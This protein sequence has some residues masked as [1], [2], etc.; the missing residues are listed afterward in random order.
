MRQTKFRGR[1]KYG[2]KLWLI[3][4]KL[5]VNGETFIYPIDETVDSPDRYEVDPET[6]G[7]FTTLFD[8]AKTEIFEFDFLQYEKHPG[9]L[10]PSGLLFVV[11]SVEWA[12]F[13]YIDQKHKYFTP[14]ANHDEIWHD[15]L[16]HCTVVGNKDN[17]SA[18]I[19]PD[20]S[21]E[22]GLH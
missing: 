2:E 12:C 8:C 10:M 13:G 17:Y 22:N 16:Q 19:K 6:V 11:W 20:Q 7:E 21:I 5:T 18:I 9:Y 1:Q 4:D 15:F 14:F 3:G